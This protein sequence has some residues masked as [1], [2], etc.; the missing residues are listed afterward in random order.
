MVQQ[1]N[2]KTL[3]KLGLTLQES[4][5]Y[6]SLIE[7]GPSKVEKIADSSKISRSDVYRTIKKLRSMGIVQCTLDKPAI[8][9]AID[10]KVAINSLLDDAQKNFE[11]TKLLSLNLLEDFEQKSKNNSEV[12]KKD[13]IL[14]AS[15]EAVVEKV[16]QSIKK[17]TKSIDIL[18]TP[19]RLTQACYNFSDC[20]QEAWA[21]KVECRVLVPRANKKQ[22]E[23]F[24]KVYP[25]N[26]CQFRLL[27]SKPKVVIVVYDKK[28]VSIFTDSNATLKGSTGLWSNNNSIL[29]LAMHYF[30]CNWTGNCDKINDCLETIIQKI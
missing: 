16:K 20:L 13:F 7:I 23:I 6:C 4:R 22:L 29:F 9:Q 11:K 8:Y 25:D 3:M 5:I 14:L 21:R 26:W 2:I 1:R 15:K 27:K 10:P 28:E 30:E 18:T 17:T 19:A 12:I 24:K